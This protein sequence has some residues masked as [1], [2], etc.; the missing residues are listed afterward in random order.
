MG[1]G[2]FR[3]EAAAAEPVERLAVELV[4][5]RALGEESARAGEA[6]RLVDDPEQRILLRPIR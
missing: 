1:A 5:G 3:R 2:S 6:V 4:G